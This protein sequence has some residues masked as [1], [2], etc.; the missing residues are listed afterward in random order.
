MNLVFD[1]VKIGLLLCF[2][3]GPVFFALLQTAVEEGF[4]ASATVGL[5]IW[6]SDI[7]YI[8]ITYFGLS[9]VGKALEA[10]NLEVVIGIIGSILFLIFGLLG[11]LTQPKNLYLPDDQLYQRNSSYFSLW[12]K[13]FLLN[14]FN[15]FTIFLWIGIMSS[16]M[17]EEELTGGRALTYF[18]SI[19]ATVV[20]TDLLK[21]FLSKRIR[22]IIKPMHLIWIRRITSFALLVFG[23]YLIIRTLML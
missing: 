21:I 16:V 2:M 18:S 5:G 4:R 17:I 13:G 23:L 9:F 15:P 22:R 12:A 19:V 20:V 10:G 7:M 3:L 6:M 11:L 8:S 1:G 14:L